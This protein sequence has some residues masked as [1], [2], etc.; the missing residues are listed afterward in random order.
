LTRHAVQGVISTQAAEGAGA[1]SIPS[2]GRHEGDHTM[3][4]RL[5]VTFCDGILEANVLNGVVRITL[6]E[7]R[8]DGKPVPCGLLV[9]PLAQLPGVANALAQLVTQVQEKLR[10]AA[11]RPAAAPPAGGGATSAGARPAASAAS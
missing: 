6:G 5:P 1:T 7:A 4:D 3:T 10:D 9:L 11:S 8:A 2:P